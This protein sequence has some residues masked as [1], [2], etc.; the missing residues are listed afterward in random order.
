MSEGSVCAQSETRDE[1]VQFVSN[2]GGR[3]HARSM[4]SS[5]KSLGKDQMVLVY[6]KGHEPSSTVRTCLRQISRKKNL[7]V[8]IY[9]LHSDGPRAAELGKIVGQ[10]RPK[11]T[12]IC[13]NSDEVGERLRLRAT[14]GKSQAMLETMVHLDSSE[15][16]ALLR[17]ELNLTQ[18]D[19]ATSMDVTPRTVQNWER[20]Q[21]VP[22]RRL[23]DLLELRALLSA[24]V[25]NGQLAAWMDSPNEAFRGQTP[26]QMIREG[27]TRDLI[28]EFRRMQSGEPL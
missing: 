20:R 11:R 16:V 25:G 5:A 22:G 7:N 2:L 24:Y 17:K 21:A 13:F 27:K 19:M 14:Q 9:S 12:H 10:L 4:L 26:R 1:A 6:L 8:V 18:T 28:L 23:R 3:P 15:S